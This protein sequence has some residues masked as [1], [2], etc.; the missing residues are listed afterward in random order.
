[1]TITLK[2]PCFYVHAGQV[3]ECLLGALDRFIDTTTR[4]NGVGPRYYTRPIDRIV[5]AVYDDEGNEIQPETTRE[6]WALACWMTRSGPE[7]IIRT[8]DTEAEA[9]AAAEK[10]YVHDIMNNPEFWVHLDR[11]SAEAELLSITE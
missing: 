9:A 1:M 7:S 4:P 10:T 11:A 6:V 3:H 8:F 2:T 5:D